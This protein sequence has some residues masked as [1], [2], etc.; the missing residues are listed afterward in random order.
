VF[1][2]TVYIID[3]LLFQSSDEQTS[4]MDGENMVH[5]TWLENLRARDNLGNL[6]SVKL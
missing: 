6:G 2:F 3:L 5:K 4:S 1:G